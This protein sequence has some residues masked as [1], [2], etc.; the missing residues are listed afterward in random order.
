[1]T[2][3]EQAYAKINLFLD[4]L[5]RR[6]D[7]FH[8]ILSVMQSVSL[9]D[10]V[11]VSSEA[12]E[13]IE[14]TVSS[15]SPDVPIDKSN[16]VY[17]IAEKY[18]YEFGISA[19]IHINIEKK[20]PIG[21]GLGGGSSDGAATLRALYR[22]FGKGSRQQLVDICAA[23]GSDLP[24]CL[25]G[26]TYLCGGRGEKLKKISPSQHLDFVIAIGK[27]RISTPT[28]YSNLDVL[29]NN[30]VDYTPMPQ[31]LMYR[32]MIADMVNDG[33]DSMPIYNVFEQVT[34]IDDVSKIKEIMT[35]YGAEISL[36]SGSGPSVFCFCKDSAEADRILLGLELAGF[37][38]F[39]CHSVFPEEFI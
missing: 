16:I 8:E 12:S 3:T 28:A 17:R 22:I 27:S 20:I 18:L 38:A 36:M 11:T 35:K 9:A 7:G 2:I 21:A 4:V 14:I 19:R 15:D 30:Y 1:M 32:Q 37:D 10:R 25:F 24:F 33:E 26:G 5:G 39:N 31:S 6:E 23:V 29:N 13:M 34:E